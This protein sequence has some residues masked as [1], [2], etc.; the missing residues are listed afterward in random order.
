MLHI[1]LRAAALALVIG[2]GG[3]I[4]SAGAQAEAPAQGTQAA[5]EV[6]PLKGTLERVKVFGKSLEGNLMGESSSPDVSIYLPPSYAKERGRRYPVVY[7]LHGYTGT[8]LGYFGNNT[9]RQLH[10]I[11]ERVFAAGVHVLLTPT[12]PTTAFKLGAISDPYEMYMSDIF[13]A[14][15]M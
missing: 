10:R 3:G 15:A 5:Q 1:A 4:V 9:G 14:T 8:D 11:A 7:L 2:V 6:A 13:T 12:A